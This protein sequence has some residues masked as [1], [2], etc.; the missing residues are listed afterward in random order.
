MVAVVGRQGPQ[1]VGGQE[2]VL[3]EELGE[4]LLQPVDADN[5]EQQPLLA[6]L[7]AQQAGF[8]ELVPGRPQAVPVEEARELLADRQRPARASSSSMTAAAS[9]GMM[10]TIDRTLTGTAVPSGVSSR[11]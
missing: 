5:A 2:L 9:T 6:G 8:A 11:S 1:P 4:Q 7:A 3:V 10:P